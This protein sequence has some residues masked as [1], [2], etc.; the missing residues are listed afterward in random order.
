MLA[1]AK[2]AFPDLSTVQEMKAV[3]GGSNLGTILLKGA[4]AADFNQ[5]HVEAAKRANERTRVG[6]GGRSS[7]ADRSFRL[8]SENQTQAAPTSPKS[9]EAGSQ[10]SRGIRW[11]ALG[12]VR[13]SIP[14]IIQ[15]RR[16]KSVGAN[17]RD[18]RSYASNRT[19]VGFSPQRSLDQVRRECCHRS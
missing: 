19:T 15:R 5:R 12:R 16:L 9:R 17:Q 7:I 8:L 10:T 3:D 18:A 4:V 13:V 6:G 14:L 11:W 2:K 1:R